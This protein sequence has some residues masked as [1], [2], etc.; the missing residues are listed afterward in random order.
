[1]SRRRNLFS[2]PWHP[3]AW[4]LG[5]MAA[6]FGIGYLASRKRDLPRLQPYDQDIEA[7]Q[8]MPFTVAVPR[9]ES[10]IVASPDVLLQAQV[11][12]GNESHLVLATMP[13]DEPEY[14]IETVVVDQ[15]TGD[16]YPIRIHARPSAALL[17]SEAP[18]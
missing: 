13:V 5:G 15:G 9:G 18:A 3:F 17:E 7:I 1:M 10:F 11:Q 8:G 2:K 14:T 4:A 12:R 16:T 6:I